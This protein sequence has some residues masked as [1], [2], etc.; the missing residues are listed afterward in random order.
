MKNKLQSLSSIA[1]SIQYFLSG[2]LISVILSSP[3]LQAQEYQTSPSSKSNRRVLEVPGDAYYP[4]AEK[5]KVYSP[6]Y[7]YSVP[8]FF[9]T[10]VNVSSDGENIVGDASNE[11]SIAFDPNNPDKMAIGWRHFETINNSFRQ[12]GIGYSSDGGITWSFDQV[13]DPGVFRSDPVLDADAQG[14]FYYNS[15]TVSGGDY[16]CDIYK[17]ENGGE[18]WNDETFGYGGDKQWFSIDKSNGP[19]SGNIYHYWSS[20]SICPPYKFTRSVDNGVSY[21]DCSGIPGNPY[22]GITSIDADGNLYVCGTSGNNFVVAKSSEAQNGTE[23][24]SWDFNKSVS[25]GG[26]IVGFGGDDCPNPQGLLGQTIIATDSSGGITNNN[27]YLLC[28]VERFQVDDPCDVMFSRSSD[29]GLTWSSPVRIND[30]EGIDAYQ[31]FGT[32][33]VAPDGRIDVIWLDTREFPGTVQSRLYYAASWDGGLTWSQNIPLGESFDPHVGWPQQNKMG[34]Y[35]DMFSTL[36]GAHLAWANTLNGEQ[37]VYY[38]FISPEITATGS[39]QENS[40]LT[41]DQNVPNPFRSQTYIG[42]SLKEQAAVTLQVFDLTGRVVAVLAEGVHSIGKH[43]V[44]FDSDGLKAGVYYY[45]LQAGKEI[46][47]R[48]LMVME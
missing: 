27:V 8:G 4:V 11:P 10:Q 31:W 7:T 33:S 48:K 19:G 18:T 24:M 46:A 37:D 35:F 44:L 2:L 14:N 34:D 12:A 16:W 32:L 45:R 38:A 26:S 23:N 28:S 17:S 47:T 25:L 22:W 42:F 15:L 36:E 9:T 20:V 30:D 39:L 21:E 5:S 40:S 13:I 43:R 41:L 29:G 3:A 1:K 6:A